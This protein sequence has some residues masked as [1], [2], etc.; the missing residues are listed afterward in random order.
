[1]SRSISVSSSRNGSVVAVNSV[2]RLTKT[3]TQL[4]KVSKIEQPI[5]LAFDE[6]IRPQDKLI[7]ITIKGNFGNVLM[8]Y[9]LFVTTSQGKLDSIDQD[10]IVDMIE[11]GVDLNCKLVTGHTALQIISGSGLPNTKD[12]MLLLIRAGFDVNLED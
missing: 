12:L 9:L 1:M 2:R 5:S 6:F 4:R 7:D 8:W 3:L 11:A 10:I